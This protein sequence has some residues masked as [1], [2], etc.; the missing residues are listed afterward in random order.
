MFFQL[1][2][3]SVYNGTVLAVSV[4]LHEESDRKDQLRAALA[5]EFAEYICTSGITVRYC[6]H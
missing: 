4:C 3:F 1:I 6:V 2:I 5:V